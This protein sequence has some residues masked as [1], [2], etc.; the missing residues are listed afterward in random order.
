MNSNKKNRVVVM[1]AFPG[2]K[3]GDKEEIVFPV[4]PP[5]DIVPL[6]ET[7]YLRKE[8]ASDTIPGGTP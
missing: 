6:R 2:D 3:Q 1:G 5:A 7:G 8:S 4:R